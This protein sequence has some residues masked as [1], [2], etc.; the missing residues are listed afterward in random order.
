MNLYQSPRLGDV[1]AHH[2]ALGLGFSDGPSPMPNQTDMDMV[3]PDFFG[4]L[5]ETPFSNMLERSGTGVSPHC[6]VFDHTGFTPTDASTSTQ[7]QLAQH[8]QAQSRSLQTHQSQPIDH[9]A[10][11]GSTEF[12][13]NGHPQDEDGDS[14]FSLSP[15]LF[16]SPKAVPSAAQYNQMSYEDISFSKMNSPEQLVM[17]SNL[18]GTLPLGSPIPRS[19]A[20][21]TVLADGCIESAKKDKSQRVPLA[22][23]H[24]GRNRSGGPRSFPGSPGD[25]DQGADEFSSRMLTSKSI[26]EKNN[27]VSAVKAPRQHM[28]GSYDGSS[29]LR[30]RTGALTASALKSS[31]S[32][33]QR[34]RSPE[35][36]ENEL[37]HGNTTAKKK[38]VEISDDKCEYSYIDAH[39]YGEAGDSP[40]LPSH[41]G[42]ATLSVRYV[43]L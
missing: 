25:A 8:H 43:T 6:A 40:E 42:S 15:S 28:L 18:G 3:S 12:A 20:G 11:Q 24:E 33:L 29:D 16:T 41:Q 21:L 23:I 10:S 38:R 35:N 22:T 5:P 37:S 30:S 19:N 2:H 32:K 36:K 14:D 4:H 34:E 31:L 7:Q 17:R 39:T 9:M 1:S 13:G 27:L 26:D